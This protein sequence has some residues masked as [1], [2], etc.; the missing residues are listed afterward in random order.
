MKI[1]A[2]EFS[3]LYH[4]YA[5]DSETYAGNSL[6]ANGKSQMKDLLELLD[7]PGNTAA[8][9]ALQISLSIDLYWQ[10]AAYKPMPPLP[11]GF[12]VVNTIT[13]AQPTTKSFPGIQSGI[14][15]GGQDSIQAGL[16]TTAI[17]NQTLSVKTTHI[18]L[19]TTVPVPQPKTVSDQP[20]K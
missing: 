17:H 2:K 6:I 19:D 11:P 10:H 20:I 1:F 8:F 7:A 18:G 4:D 15:S 9:V 16:W 12:S 5:S 14:L 13:I 3:D